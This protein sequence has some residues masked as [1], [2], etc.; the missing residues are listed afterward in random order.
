MLKRWRVIENEW[1]LKGEPWSG[2]IG[3]EEID[4][5]LAVP[6]IVCWF[7]RGWDDSDAMARHVCDLHNRH[8]DQVEGK[9]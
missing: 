6:G 7:T 9:R 5:D 1:N 2:A 4:N 3:I 8:L